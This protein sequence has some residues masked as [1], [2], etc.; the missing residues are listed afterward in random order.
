MIG[1]I[2]IA[3][4]IRN[5]TA[6]YPNAVNFRT[7]VRNSLHVILVTLLMVLCFEINVLVSHFV[8]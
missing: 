2:G 7:A 6:A 1:V 3:I 5:T 4:I 8:R